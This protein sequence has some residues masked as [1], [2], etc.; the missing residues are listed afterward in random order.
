MS[1]Q[2]SDNHYIEYSVSSS[3]VTFFVFYSSWYHGSSFWGV[4]FL[5][6]FGESKLKKEPM[7]KFKMI[8]RKCLIFMIAFTIYE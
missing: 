7:L 6:N 4:I 3:L 8:S 1:N 5:G 2:F